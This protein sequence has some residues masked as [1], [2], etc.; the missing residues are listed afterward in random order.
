MYRETTYTKP[1][2]GDRPFAKFVREFLIALGRGN[3]EYESLID[4]IKDARRW[5]L[6]RPASTKWSPSPFEEGFD[7]K[8]LFHEEFD[9]QG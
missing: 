6:K 4:A 9:E 3:I 1:G 5:A 8:P 7:E 2:A